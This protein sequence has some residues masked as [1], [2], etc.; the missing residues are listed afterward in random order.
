MVNTFIK[1]QSSAV[2]AIAAVLTFITLIIQINTGRC[3]KTDFT[4]AGIVS[5]ELAWDQSYADAIRKAWQMPCHLVQ[6][7]CMDPIKTPAIIVAA[8][9][10]IKWDFAFILTYVTL[11]YVLVVLHEEKFS[12]VSRKPYSGIVG[13]ICITAGL[14]D[15]FE[16]ILMLRHLNGGDIQ[17]WMIA[18]LA[19]A[20]GLALALVAFYIL[21]RG[22]YLKRFSAFTI[23]LV[24]ILWENRVSVIG[25]LVLY[26]SL[27]KSDQGQDLLINLNAS[28]WGPGTFY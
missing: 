22:T 16:N 10:N 12:K 8:V 17:S 9:D 7:L 23:V 18:T 6:P 27:W 24:H 1:N 2:L 26:F 15:C 25:L 19:S 20:K 5:L 21:R 11:L 3:L 4:P 28:H 13:T 14:L